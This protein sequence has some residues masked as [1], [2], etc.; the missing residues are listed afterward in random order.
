MLM[1]K[2]SKHRK[3]HRGTR[4]GLAQRGNTVAFGEMFFF[5][6]N[7]LLYPW[8]GG[9]NGLPNVPKPVLFGFDFRDP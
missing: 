1:P 3:V 6:E 5:L 7:S 8:T 2:R 9:E 4:G